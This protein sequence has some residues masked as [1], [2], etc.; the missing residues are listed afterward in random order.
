MKTNNYLD[1]ALD[2]Q[3]D[4]RK[5]FMA[6]S[7]VQATMPHS[8]PKELTFI[9]K[10][11]EYTMMM[12]GHPDCG[13][14]YGSI[15]RLLMSWLTTEAVK[16]KS[17]T[18]ELGKSLRS[19]MT[20]LDMKASGGKTGSITML[21]DQMKRL[22]TCHVSLTRNAKTNFQTQNITPIKSANLWWN[23]SDPEQLSLFNSTVTLS[24]D[25]FAEIIDRPVVFRLKTLQ[26]LK[27]SSLA[28]DLYIWITYRNS[29]TQSRSY[30]PW[31]MLQLQFGANYPETTRG[32]LDFKRNFLATLKKVAIA[33]PEA[34]K[35]EW[36]S[37]QLI[38]IPG[39]P[40]VPKL[41]SIPKP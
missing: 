3:E 38:F 37:K 36:N 10:N 39:Y 12:T 19:F 27:S 34:K 40:D 6:R 28:V 17:P 32:K 25:F 11:G 30:I 15:P 5:G 16:T 7:W 20:A 29:Y 35:L 22:F 14:P 8:R 13:L 33:Y 1:V 24:Q 23:P 2:V 31:E 9:R 4:L 21:K 41:I 26:L 18:V